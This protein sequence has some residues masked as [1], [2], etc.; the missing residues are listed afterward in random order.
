LQ[1]KR[2]GN[3][4]LMWKYFLTIDAIILFFIFLLLYFKWIPAF[5][6]NQLDLSLAEPEIQMA[7]LKQIQ[8]EAR[9]SLKIDWHDRI[10]IEKENRRKGLGEQGIAAKLS[11]RD[12]VNEAKISLANGFNGLLSDKI[13]VNRSLP[14]IRHPE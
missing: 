3:A 14:D 9:T 5:T 12:K 1:A 6:E 2:P 8:P 11:G 7:R 10:L 13:S 4:K